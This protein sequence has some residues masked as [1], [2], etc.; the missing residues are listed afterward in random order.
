M[1]AGTF[2]DMSEERDYAHMPALP[3]ENIDRGD[4]FSIGFF[5]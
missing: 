4:Y 2:I 3:A 1:L 5:L